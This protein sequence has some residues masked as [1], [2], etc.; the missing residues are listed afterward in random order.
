M[1]ISTLYTQSSKEKGL[2]RGKEG[3][4]L[5]PIRIRAPGRSGDSGSVCCSDFYVD[6]PCLRRSYCLEPDDLLEYSIG[7]PECN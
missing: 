7:E 2:H 4:N 5:G 6:D 1:Q 3:G